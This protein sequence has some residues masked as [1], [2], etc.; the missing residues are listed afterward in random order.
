MGTC[1][2]DRNSRLIYNI[3]SSNVTAFREVNC[4]PL[5]HVVT[6]KQ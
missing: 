4:G 2:P 1:R 5:K 3:V 6:A